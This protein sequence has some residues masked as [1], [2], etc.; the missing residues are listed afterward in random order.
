MQHL[1]NNW[2]FPHIAHLVYF[3]GQLEKQTIW[4]I[5]LVIESS[6]SV[7][8]QSSRG[9]KQKSTHHWFTPIYCSS[10][11]SIKFSES[12]RILNALTSW[13]HETNQQ[14]LTVNAQVNTTQ[15]RNSISRAKAIK[16]RGRKKSWLITCNATGDVFH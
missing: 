11:W 15:Q 4:A 5:K 14:F 1:C 2:N 6:I 3:S 10:H 7:K 9:V 8:T 13:V 16:K 12:L